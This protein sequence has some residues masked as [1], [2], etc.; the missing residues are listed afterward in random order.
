M[1]KLLIILAVIVLL[2]GGYFVTHWPQKLPVIVPIEVKPIAVVPAPIV[3][4]PVEKPVKI[5]E[6]PAAKTIPAPAPAVEVSLPEEVAW[7]VVFASQAPLGDWA[8]PYQEACEEASL[9]LVSK[10]FNGETLTP[11]I[12]DYEILKLIKWEEA[13]P[14]YATDMNAEEVA[15][16]AREYFNL[17]VN[18]VTEVTVDRIKRELAAGHLIVAPFAGRMLGNPNFKGA[19]PLYHMLVI[20]GYDENNF[21]T[22]DVG[23]RKGDNYK[24]N[25]QVLLNAIHDLPLVAGKV[26]RPYDDLETADADKAALMA[27]GPRA[28]LVFTK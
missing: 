2:L 10:Y 26:F 6:Q 25:Q 24:Y 17:K 3:P 5:D 28:M 23:T 13:R 21:F 22:N 1:R 14:N 16:I 27:A 8:L 7:P 19:G 11:E 12:M 20:R 9:I 4:V 18:V 15:E